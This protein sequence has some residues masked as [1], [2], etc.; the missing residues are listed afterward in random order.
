ML[1]DALVTNTYMHVYLIIQLSAIA[2]S[3]T[4]GNVQKFCSSPHFP[5][6]DDEDGD[7]VDDHVQ[8][9]AIKCRLKTES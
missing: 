4:G 2:I 8:A 7:Y 6:G 1:H 9:M 5:G 3:M